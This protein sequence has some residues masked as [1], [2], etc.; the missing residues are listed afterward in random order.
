MRNKR[1]LIVLLAVSFLTQTAWAGTVHFESIDV[2]T[3]K[4]ENEVTL[5]IYPGAYHDFDW[6]GINRVVKGHRV[7]Y[8][9][10]A[11]ADA[12]VQVKNHLA[13]HFK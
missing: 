8:H 5:K 1:V 13:Q 6:K 11:A 7:R 10:E 3:E 4:T 9:P 12:I 2:G